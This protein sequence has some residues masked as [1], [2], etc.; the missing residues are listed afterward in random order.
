MKK[1]FTLCLTLTLI[2]ALCSC[3]Q[4]FD[5]NEFIGKSS[6]EIV[7]QYGEFDCVTMPI[8]SDGLYRNC[9]CGYTIKDATAGFLGTTPEILFFISF[10]KNGIATQCEEG[11]RPGG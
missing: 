3:S 11:Y 7:E 1:F 10:D 5:K 8:S 4:K 6:K 2:F 9:R